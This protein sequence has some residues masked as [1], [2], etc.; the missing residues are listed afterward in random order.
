MNIADI[1]CRFLP[2]LQLAASQYA[3]S[4]D[5]QSLVDM[6]DQVQK[7]SFFDGYSHAID[8][9][10]DNTQIQEGKTHEIFINPVCYF[11]L[12]MKK[13]A[14]WGA[15]PSKLLLM[16]YQGWI[17]KNNLNISSQSR[18]TFLHNVK[19]LIPILANEWEYL[20]KPRRVGNAMSC[21]E[22]LLDEYNCTD[23]MINPDSKDRRDRIHT[24][25]APVMARGLFKRNYTPLTVNIDPDSIRAD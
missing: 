1:S 7:E 22:P 15:Y 12:D 23:W 21:D 10:R 6:I 19:S 11:L 17:T 14:S 2:K 20:D 8:V 9:L 18:N 16:M 13:N 24:D 25:K 3:T 5:L 4:G